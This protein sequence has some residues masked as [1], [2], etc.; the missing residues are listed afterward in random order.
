[1]DK[2]DQYVRLMQAK[3]DEWKAEVDLLSA[4]AKLVTAGL[5][6]DYSE[7]IELLA[8]KQ[9]VARHKLEE[10]EKSGA[11]A[12]EDLKVGLESAWKAMAEALNLARAR[13]K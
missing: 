9:T 1:M 3:L 13:F 4:K 12:W 11:G 2:K 7:Q 10:L 5:K 6:V 8:Q